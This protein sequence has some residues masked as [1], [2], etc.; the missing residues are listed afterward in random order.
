MTARSDEA[1][2]LRLIRAL[3]EN[4]AELRRAR[5]RKAKTRR[6]R[7][8]RGAQAMADVP[9][10]DIAAAAARRALSRVGE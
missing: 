8:M 4:T 7:A 10:S 5:E 3:E 2:M 6:V 9:V 1:A